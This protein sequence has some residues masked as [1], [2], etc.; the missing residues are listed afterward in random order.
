MRSKRF[1]LVG[2]LAAFILYLAS[3]FVWTRCFT[4]GGHLW[5]FFRPP[6]GLMSVDLPERYRPFGATPWEGWQRVESIPGTLF[7][8]CILVDD[9]LTG[10]T[11]LPTYRGM[12]CFG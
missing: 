8:P 10:K 2:C 7:Y 11:Y 1:I 4:S 12:V 9:W 3:Y 5:S 6:A